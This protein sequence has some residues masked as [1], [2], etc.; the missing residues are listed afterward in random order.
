[1]REEE[2]QMEVKFSFGA[3]S[4][5]LEEQANKQGYTLGDEA[6]KL[7]KMKEARTMLFLHGIINDSLAEQT[8]KKINTKVV[9]AL[10]PLNYEN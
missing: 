7:E 3:M 8:A 6:N 10:L 1:M 5:T 4:P 9:N 2:I